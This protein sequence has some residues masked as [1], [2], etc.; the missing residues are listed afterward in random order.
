VRGESEA[1]FQ[2][3]V[4]EYA[5]RRGWR[6]AHF[7]KAQNSRGVWRTPVAGDG[8]GFP[9]L[10]LLRGERLIVAELKKD[11][12]YPSPEQRA[13]LEAWRGIEGADVRVWRPRD[14]S[15]IESSLR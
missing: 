13:W 14:W 3:V 11:D 15:E 4:I 2:R 7:R 5:Q 12:A 9:D 8:K 6:V 10:V 1:A